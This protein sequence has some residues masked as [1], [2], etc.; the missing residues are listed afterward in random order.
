MS[1][2]IFNWAQK[3]VQIESLKC[4]AYLNNNLKLFYIMQKKNE[5]YFTAL[6][7]GLSAFIVSTNVNARAP[8]S[9]MTRYLGTCV[10]CYLMMFEVFQNNF[11]FKI[12]IDSFYL[13]KK[14][15][16]LSASENDKIA[17]HFAFAVVNADFIV[18]CKHPFYYFLWRV[19]AKT[20][21][22][23]VKSAEEI[24]NAKR[25]LFVSW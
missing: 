10:L 24:A 23:T 8:S 20:Q 3:C 25:K 1:S 14:I 4:C 6:F 15:Y 17:L 16:C 13:S 21:F 18:N 9:E 19:A 2:S 12:K 22:T 11:F 5:I 7:T